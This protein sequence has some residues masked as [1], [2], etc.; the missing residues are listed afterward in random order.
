MKDKLSDLL[1]E[2]G[3]VSTV[4]KQKFLDEAE[5]IELPK[6]HHIFLE[7][8]ENNCEYILISG[9]LHRYNVSDRGDTVTTNRTR[10][11]ILQ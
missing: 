9:V 1:T 6:N 10:T 2:L 5:V 3:I 4:S 11:H 8:K 7:G